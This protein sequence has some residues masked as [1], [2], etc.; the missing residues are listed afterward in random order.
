[1][2]TMLR[3]TKDLDQDGSSISRYAYRGSVSSPNSA[4]V[5][6]PSGREHTIMVIPTGGAS[7]LVETTCDSAAD[8][9]AD[10]ATWIAWTAGTVAGATVDEVVGTVTAIRVTAS[11]AGSVNYR[12]LAGGLTR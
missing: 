7:A 8:V 4:V 5:A 10:T 2:A 3:L 11:V 9:I 1:M 6:T 12:V